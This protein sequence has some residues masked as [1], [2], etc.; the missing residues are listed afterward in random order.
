MK[1]TNEMDAWLI[2]YGN[3][4]NDVRKIIYFVFQCQCYLRPRVSTILGVIFTLFIFQI[5]IIDFM[6]CNVFLKY[7]IVE[8]FLY[9]LTEIYNLIISKLNYAQLAHLALKRVK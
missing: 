7:Q 8:S 9:L 6:E 4:N 3:I 5:I 2:V 1:F